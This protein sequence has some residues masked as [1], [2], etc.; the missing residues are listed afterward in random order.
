MR[1]RP[2]LPMICP[3]VRRSCGSTRLHCG[4]MAER[5]KMLFGVKSPG[6]PRNIVL[7]VGPDPPQRGERDSL[8]PSPLFTPI[9]INPITTKNKDGISSRNGLRSG[10]SCKINLL[11]NR[12]MLNLWII[13]D[14]LWN[15][16]ETSRLTPYTSDILQLSII[17]LHQMQTIVTDLHGVC[18][19]VRQSVCL[20]HSS[21]WRPAG[22]ILGQPS[23]NHFGLLSFLLLLCLK[24]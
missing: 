21:T 3:S 5:I 10:L 15:K 1:C 17:R 18:L 9:S 12:A 6:G 13:I 14:S 16:N 19:S 11:Q 4:K 24:M 22:V 8:Q 20:S 2:L 7:D 23:P